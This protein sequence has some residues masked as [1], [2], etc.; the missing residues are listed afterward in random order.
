MK[1]QR[2]ATSAAM[3]AAVVIILIAVAGVGYLA[4]S[5][6]L[7]PAPVSSTLSTPTSSTTTCTSSQI[8]ATTTSDSVVFNLENMPSNFTVGD[9]R[10]VMLYNGT[11]YSKSSNGSATINLG[12]SLV[13]N[14]TQG[15]EAQ[16]AMFGS[17]PP[18]PYPPAV[19]L[20]STAAAFDG[21]VHM[22]WVATCSAIFF[23]IALQSAASHTMRSPSYS[24]TSLPG[25]SAL[26]WRLAHTY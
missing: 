14:I 17:P 6:V 18:A 22:Q 11:G 15:S 13:F 19:P 26:V 7:H 21:N 16:I 8:A 25:P 2:M 5:S 3:I 1:H 9:Y 20:P 24:M 10:F 23:E 12:Y 4:Y